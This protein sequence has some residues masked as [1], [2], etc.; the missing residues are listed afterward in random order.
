MARPSRQSGLDWRRCAETPRR[1]VDAGFPAREPADGRLFL[2][3]RRLIAVRGLGNYRERMASIQ[4]PYPAGPLATLNR[5]W[6]LLLL[7]FGAPA[8]QAAGKPRFSTDILPILSEHCFSCHGPDE[9]HRKG[10]L[11]LD[12]RGAATASGAVVPGDP[13]GSELVRR[14]RSAEAF[15]LMPPPKHGKPLDERKKQVLEAWIAE[16]A[17][18]GKH[19]AFEQP[20][21]VAPPGGTG[22]PGSNPIDQFVL[23]NLKANGLGLSPRAPDATLLARASLDLTG[24]PPT[25][26]EREAFFR[27]TRPGR[28]ERQV[29][30]LL[31][32]PHHGERMAMWWLDAARYAD[33]DGYQADETRSNWPWRDWVIQAFN[34]NM[35][36]DQ[37]TLE[38]FAGDL[39]PG[40]TP[41]QKLATCF[42]RN[43]MTNGEGGRDPEESRID[44]VIDRT[45]TVGTVWLGLTL[46]CCQCHSHK[47]DPVSQAEYY[48]L[49]AFFNSIDE[50]GKA[51]KGARPFLAYA[52]PFAGRAVEEAGLLVAERQATERAGRADAEKGFEDW[53][54]RQGRAVAGGFEPWRLLRANRLE[55]VEGSRLCQGADGAIESVGANP[56]QD[57]Y[58]VA[59]R[60]QVGRITG[61]RLEIA[62]GAFGKER[63]YSRGAS[64]EFILTD[65]KVQ[66]RG[67]GASQARDLEISAAFADFSADPKIARGYGD[68]KG[69][70]DDDPR[71]GWTTQGEK[72]RR[73]HLAVFA[74]AEPLTLADG[75]EVVLELRQ[76]STEGDANIGLFR[77]W[78]TD[79]TGPALRGVEPMPLEALANAGGD[80]GRL[81][82]KSRQRLR[83]QYLSDHPVYQSA[84]AS[85]D[86]A[87]RQLAEAK[88]A[89]QQV[90]VMVLAER[91]EPRPTHLLERGVWDKKG[92][93]VER[94]V[95]RAVSAWPA[96]VTTDRLGLARWLNS[97]ENPLTARVVVNHLWQLCFGE[98]LVRTP[99]DFGLQGERPTHPELL[100]W[101]AVEFME[102]GWDIRHLLRLMVTSD[103]YTQS[104]V[105]SGEL[106]TRD[107]ANR[108][109]GR[110]SRY[111]LPS[112]MLRDAALARAGLLNRE[113]G[114]P[115]VRPHQPEGLWEE[116]FM[117]RFHYEPSEGPAQYRRTMYAFWR[118]SIAPAF[119]FD[120]AQR[121]VCEVRVPRTNTPLQALTLLN[122]KTMLECAQALAIRTVRTGMDDRATVDEL[123]TLVPG[124]AWT[125]DERKLLDGELAR[126]MA[127][128]S[129]HGAEAAKLLAGRLEKETA[130]V[131]QDKIPVVA[132]RLVVASLLLNLDEAISRE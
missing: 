79:Q 27:D 57:D 66:V 10:D 1:K 90:E 127:Y 118:R 109:L 101:L 96:G 98:G 81:D 47:Y 56:R 93:R 21:K 23:A 85:L 72:E 95:P 11:R 107:P 116:N 44:Y 87:N 62:P 76:R 111:R 19:W 92:T 67:Q 117:G 128:Y 119:L 122:D 70:L 78:A 12:D 49:S 75:E 5:G 33:T 53:L 28:W 35:R 37:F 131:A 42:H 80:P 2:F 103:T 18:W 41:E 17:P 124:R 99:E 113:L 22:T 25:P 126:V 89:A 102:S 125:A 121:R 108:L 129:T 58:R 77:L 43:H 54:V 59:A 8:A 73:P 106:L 84:R 50:D 55:T 16:G 115:P 83:E 15:S 132:A 30:R 105:V 86:R 14:I 48:S 20:V 3:L 63:A 4:K 36:F 39:L 45:N 112:W 13:A 46:G 52:S 130:A 9:K 29:D 32:S 60:P 6:L 31:A 64:G 71:N 38:Q 24:L 97:R 61:F 114:G 91:R 120:T 94:G 68:I 51:G 7:A 34:R 40:S 110:M 26:A 74:L 69:T 88:K 65:F 123:G 100:D 104:S 82:D